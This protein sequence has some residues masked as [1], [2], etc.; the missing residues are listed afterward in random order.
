MKY[1]RAL[2]K[3]DESCKSKSKQKQANYFRIN[4][5]SAVLN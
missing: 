5:T 3:K 1:N 4:R 2:R